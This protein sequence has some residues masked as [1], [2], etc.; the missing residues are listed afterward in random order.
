MG[1]ILRC[2]RLDSTPIIIIPII[3]IVTTIAIGVPIPDLVI[4]IGTTV[5][6]RPIIRSIDAGMATAAIGDAGVDAVAVDMGVPSD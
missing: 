1:I 5:H 6:I 3:L 2:H 4:T